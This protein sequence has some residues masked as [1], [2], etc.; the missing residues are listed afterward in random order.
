MPS[1]PDP[2]AVA[3]LP[4]ASQRLLRRVDSMPDQAWPGPSLLPGWTR[5][6]VVAHVALNAEALAGVLRGVVGD[7]PTPMYAS[8]EQRDADIA[9]LATAEPGEIRTRLL[10]ATTLFADAVAAMPPDSWEGSFERT[11]GGPR[12][13]IARVLEMRLR[14]VEIHHADLGLGYH[15]NDWPAEF[16]HHLVGALA[17][18]VE[19]PLRLRATDAG[20]TWETGRGSAESAPDTTPAPPT[21][22]GPVADLA[23]WLTGRGEGAGLTIDSGSLPRIGAL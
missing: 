21:V 12:Y 17:R 20:A 1:L 9:D 10:G 15:H 2:A 22:S 7:D 13:R 3:L 16:S 4:D 18:R 23:W 5:A 6:H 19:V 11:P 8:Q 14:E